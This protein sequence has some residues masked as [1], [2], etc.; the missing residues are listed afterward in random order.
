MSDF[1]YM[2]PETDEE[3]IEAVL[4]ANNGMVD[5]TI[6]QLLTM[7]IDAEV[8]DDDDLSDKILQTLERDLQ[9]QQ[10]Q[11]PHLSQNAAGSRRAGRE[12]KPS[13]RVS[14]GR[15]IYRLFLKII[16]V[17]RVTS[18]YENNHSSILVC[19]VLTFLII[20]L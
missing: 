1:C 10:T 14:L 5:A 11:S 6:D 2:F 17:P 3:V 13:S 9:Q 7:N 16:L 12:S 8:N 18:N 20:K 15:R 19:F 4:R